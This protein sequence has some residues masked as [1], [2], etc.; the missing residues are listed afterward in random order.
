[1]NDVCESVGVYYWCSGIVYIDFSKVFKFFLF[2]FLSAEEIF[3][4]AELVDSI[5]LFVVLTVD[6]VC[7]IYLKEKREKH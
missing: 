3:F 6:L 4:V 2:V 1:M 5:L 7:G